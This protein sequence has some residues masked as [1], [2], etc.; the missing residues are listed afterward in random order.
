VTG[1]VEKVTGTP[2]RS[3]AEWANEHAD[4]F[5]Q[6]LT[7]T[8]SRSAGMA[9]GPSSGAGSSGVGM[10]PPAATLSTVSSPASPMVPKIV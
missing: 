6:C 8:L 7:F 3:F 4:A 9:G 2:A 1:T 10:T 5:R